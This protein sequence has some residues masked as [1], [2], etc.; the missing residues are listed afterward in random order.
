[1]TLAALALVLAAAVLHAAWNLLAKR[2]DGGLPFVWLAGVAGAVI[3][4]PAAVA[5]WILAKPPASGRALLL[6]AGSGVL[7]TAYYSALQ[8]SYR[9]GDLSLVYPLARGAGALLAVGGAALLFEERPTPLSLAGV[10][11]L[12]AGVLTLAT[13][14]RGRGSDPRKGVGLA[15]ATGLVICAYTL[16]DAS[17]VIEMAVPALA[18]VWAGDLGRSVLLTPAAR[19]RPQDVRSLWERHRLEVLGVAVLSPLAYLLVLAALLLAPVSYVAPARE[20]S[21]LIGVLLGYRL[22]GE[23]HP[24]RPLVAAVVVIVGMACL[25]AA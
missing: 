5:A 10:V 1:M 24:G 8:M 22:L 13:G 14:G 21:V 11:L 16:W 7:H 18:I 15:L 2:A 23:G 4:A 6:L 9:W 19:H 20:V 12:T 17:L 25:T 3:W